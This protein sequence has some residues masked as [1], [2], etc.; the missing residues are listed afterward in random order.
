MLGKQIAFRLDSEAKDEEWAKLP[1]KS[2]EKI[3]EFYA[4]LITRIAR[5]SAR[6]SSKE[7]R[8]E[9]IHE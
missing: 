8:S 6:H 5:C 4:R 2:R 9:N 1:L 7:T 3:I